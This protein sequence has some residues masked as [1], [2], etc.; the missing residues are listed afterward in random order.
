MENSPL[1]RRAFLKSGAATAAALALAAACPAPSD[2]AALVDPYRGV[3]PMT[4][5]IRRGLY[6]IYNNWHA[7]RVGTILSYNHR[8]RSWLRAHDGV[9]IFAPRGTTLFACVPGTVVSYWRPFS[10]YGNTVWIRNA[11]GYLF[12]YCHLD[13]VYVRPGQRVTAN[14]VVGTL[15]KT[16]N[17]ARTPAHLHFELHYPAGSTYACVRCSPHKMVNA[18]NPYPSLR[19]ATLHR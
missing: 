11:A 15:G 8:L 10:V 19:A 17:A 16:G 7:S 2:A 1:T 18:I 14:T 13:R 9:D 5:P 3:V 6:W 4:F 12:F